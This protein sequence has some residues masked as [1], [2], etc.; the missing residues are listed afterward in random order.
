MEQ[1]IQSK[2]E[3]KKVPGTNFLRSGIEMAAVIAG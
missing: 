3:Q 2:V 1:K